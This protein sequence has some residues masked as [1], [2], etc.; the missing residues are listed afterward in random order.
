MT[1]PPEYEVAVVGAGAAGLTTAIY[2]ARLGPRVAVIDGEGGRHEAVARVHN[3]IGVSPET[4]GAALGDR[5]A[6]VLGH[7]DHAA[8]VAMLLRNVTA[9]PP[10][11]PGRA[12]RR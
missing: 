10:V 4:A 12:R 9:E 7:D 2:A 5:P 1:Q 8:E 11:G 6:F 3:L